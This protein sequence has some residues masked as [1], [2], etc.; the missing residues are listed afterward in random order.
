MLLE[1]LVLARFV[2]HK[3]KQI[4]MRIRTL[5]IKRAHSTEHVIE[6]RMD[7]INVYYTDQYLESIFRPSS[8]PHL[9]EI[10]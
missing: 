5:F 9:C 8:G 7:L 3:T 4:N 10:N 2:I 1:K 6:N